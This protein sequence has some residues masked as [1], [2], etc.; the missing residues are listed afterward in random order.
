MGAA[1]IN[2]LTD[3]L[4]LRASSVFAEINLTDI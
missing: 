3:D 2:F 4:V 1:L